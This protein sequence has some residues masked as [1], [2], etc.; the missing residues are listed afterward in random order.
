MDGASKK[1]KESYEDKVSF[2]FYSPACL[3]VYVTMELEYARF[4]ELVHRLAALGEKPR[5][6]PFPLSIQAGMMYDVLQIS[7]LNKRLKSLKTKQAGRKSSKA[8]K[9][10]KD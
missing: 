2:G 1:D 6:I 3:L 9:S 5:T 7:D 10:S 4:V 8:S